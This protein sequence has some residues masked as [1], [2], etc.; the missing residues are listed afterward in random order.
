MPFIFN[1]LALLMSIAALFGAYKAAGEDK[2]D[3]PFRA[4][5]AASYAHQSNSGVTVGADP[6]STAEKAKTAFGK[7]D[8]NKH[9]LLP[10]LVVIQ[11][12]S[13]KAIRADNLKLEYI[14]PD[15]SR[16][17]VTPASEVKYIGG[18]RR[19]NVMS[20][21]TGVPKVL[22]RKNPLDAWEI[23]G[24]A[25]SAK[26]IPP[27]ESA[28]GFFYFEARHLRGSRLY[29]TGLEEAETRKEL[30]YYEIPFE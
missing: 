12:D 30:F 11:N 19:P 16:V 23:E 27:G 5:P 14:G 17:A 1:R 29:L 20:G 21:P 4:E 8:P 7:L 15:R 13:G 25:F 26:M 22:K 28:S 24:R 3:A 6:F 9:G 18:P 10:I 2:K